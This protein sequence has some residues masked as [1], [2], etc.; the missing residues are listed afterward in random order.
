VREACLAKKNLEGG[1]LQK[2]GG[3]KGNPKA[4]KIVEGSKK[5]IL[6]ARRH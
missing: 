2:L 4:K 3:R 6:R 5:K 1:D